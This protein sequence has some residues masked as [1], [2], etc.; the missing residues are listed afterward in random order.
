MAKWQGGR[1]PAFREGH[2]CRTKAERL[3]AEKSQQLIATYESAI[4]SLKDAGAMRSVVNLENEIKKEK[5]RMRAFSREDP[6][7]LLALAQRRD[8]EEA[9]ERQRQQT[10]AVANAR[11]LTAA[12]LRQEI[13]D[14]QEILKK[15]KREIL[16]AECLLEM[17]HA[18]KTYSLVDLGDG[19]SCG[20]KASG[21]NGTRFSTDCSA[22]AVDYRQR[23]K[24]DFAWWKDAWDKKMLEEYGAEWARVFAEWVQKV[25]ADF[26]NGVGNAFSLFV[27]AETR[28]CFHDVVALQVP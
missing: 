11:T 26:D 18:M 15:R 17:K 20:G 8:H 4:I 23:K 1:T 6:E 13:K 12:K 27:H 9:Q 28:R 10:I 2:L 5:R 21:K 3:D 14:N 16:D 24:N 25:L 7:V 22:V 19:R